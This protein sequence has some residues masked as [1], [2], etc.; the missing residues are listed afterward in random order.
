MNDIFERRDGEILRGTKAEVR[1][2][3]APVW[4]RMPG[5]RARA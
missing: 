1:E 5:E 4:E 3:L 2:S